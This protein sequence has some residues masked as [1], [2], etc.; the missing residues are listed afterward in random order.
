[1]PAHPLPQL[2]ALPLLLTLSLPAFSAST[3]LEGAAA[4]TGWTGDAPGVCRH[5]RYADL[6]P[7]PNGT[8]PE[9]QP[10]KKLET[11]V[12]IPDKV[13]PK[14][15]EGFSVEVFANG[16]K[17]P[18]TLRVAPNGDTFMSESGA[19]RV[20]VFRAGSKTPAVPEVFAEGL[21]RPSGIAFYPAKN[22]KFVYIAEAGKVVRY[23]Y[24]KGDVK[25]SGPAEVIVSGI[26]TSR[27]WMRDLAISADGKQIFLAVASGT[28]VAG[29]MPDKTAEEI[30]T[31][32][33]A[34]GVG[35]AWGEELD[36][37]VVRVFDP[38]GKSIRNYATGLRNCSGLA[39]QAKENQLWC[40]VIE[41]D[42]LGPNLVPD[43]MVRVR[44]GDFHGWPWFYLNGQEDPAWKGKR[45]DLQPH[46]RAPD[47]M[48]TPHSSPI[49]VVF[50]EA[51]AF[52]AEYRGDAFVTVHGS[53]SRPERSGYKVVRMRMENGK[54]T[55]EQIDFMTGFL[56][57]ND[58]AWGRPSGIAVAADGALLVSDDASGTVFRVKHK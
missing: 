23:P 51:K 52:P 45:P 37:G 12:P 4:L 40:V 6:P 8:E 19:G 9:K 34:H 53:H 32:E 29:G 1:M 14:V 39:I 27:H 31:H 49:S 35:A 36:R 3:C 15:P 43:M 5:L 41:R 21:E 50:Y 58:H 55:G 47:F 16:F 28:N 38:A 33:K 54:P 24:K 2:L 10:D 25:P 11:I 18:R 7:A 13:L 20:L 48:L 26:P 30:K 22:P 56:V 17:M 57:D 46:V 42:H 44:D